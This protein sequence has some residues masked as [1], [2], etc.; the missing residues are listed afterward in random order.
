MHQLFQLL[1]IV[2]YMWLKLRN[3][4]SIVKYTVLFFVMV[5]ITIKT[6]QYN[7]VYTIVTVKKET[8]VNQPVQAPV[9]GLLFKKIEKSLIE[10]FAGADLPPIKFAGIVFLLLF[11]SSFIFVLGTQPKRMPCPLPVTSLRKQVVLQI[12]RL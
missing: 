9:H 10:R 4:E 11:I 5:F 7:F 3:K 2:D 1:I 12:F 8:S 6:T